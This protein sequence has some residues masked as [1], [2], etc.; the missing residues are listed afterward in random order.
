MQAVH[1]LHHLSEAR[2]VD[3]AG[4]CSGCPRAATFQAPPAV[5]LSLLPTCILTAPPFIPTTPALDPY[6]LHPYTFTSYIAHPSS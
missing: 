2:S 3:T 6:N 5:P 4:I 1:G